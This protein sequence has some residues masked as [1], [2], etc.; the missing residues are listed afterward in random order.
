MNFRKRLSQ[1]G[2]VW[3]KEAGWKEFVDD[4]TQM[5]PV[6][7]ILL[8]IE[9]I[10][11]FEPSTKDLKVTFGLG[12]LC[13]LSFLVLLCKGL[14]FW[15][16]HFPSRHRKWPQVGVGILYT[17]CIYFLLNSIG[18]YIDIPK[19][20]DRIFWWGLVILY[21]IILFFVGKIYTERR[22]SEFF[23][24]NVLVL[25]TVAG[26]LA[27]LGWR[28]PIGFLIILLAIYSGVYWAL[29]NRKSEIRMDLE[30]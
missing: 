7:V 18:V 22:W 19:G 2:Q 8:I 17:G 12:G 15:V 28:G 25:S 29:K 1:K 16:V 23:I 5:I 30:S 3:F 21:L 20:E 10:L 26:I 6:F 27:F 9:S 13:L 4:N 24:L 11:Y 14:P